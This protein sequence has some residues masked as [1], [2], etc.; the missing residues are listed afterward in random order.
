MM[1]GF[2]LAP[3]A[4][5]CPGSAANPAIAHAIHCRPRHR[6]Q[7]PGASCDARLAYVEQFASVTVAGEGDAVITADGA[8]SRITWRLAVLD[9]IKECIESLI[10]F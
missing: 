9:A 1:E 2:S 3:L 4:R 5:I 8:K 7:K 6:Q 10:N